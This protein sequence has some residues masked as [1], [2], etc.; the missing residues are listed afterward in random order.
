MYISTFW[1]TENMKR[2]KIRIKYEKQLL[3]QTLHKNNLISYLNKLPCKIKYGF[4][5]IFV[6]R[7]IWLIEEILITE[8]TNWPKQNFDSLKTAFFF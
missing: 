4:K 6:S 2:W 7:K 1:R 3:L 8:N 5:L